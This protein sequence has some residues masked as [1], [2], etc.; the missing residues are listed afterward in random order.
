MFVLN[1]TLLS[2]AAYCAQDDLKNPLLT[3]VCGHFVSSSNHLGEHGGILTAK[4]FEILAAIQNDSEVPIALSLIN[5]IPT[6][7]KNANAFNK[8]GEYAPS[9]WIKFLL[10]NSKNI[11][12]RQEYLAQIICL[13]WAFD[14]LAEQQGESFSRGSFTIVDP[15]HKI[16]NFLLGYVR[17]VTGKKEPKTLPLVKTINNFAS[18]RKPELH[19]SSHHYGQT[20]EAQFGIDVRFTADQTVYGLLPSRHRHVLFG[21]LDVPGS[22]LPLTFVKFEPVGLGSSAEFF[23]HLLNFAN[24]GQVSGE[25]RREK[26]IPD[27]ITEAFET[28]VPN[29][30][31]KRLHQMINHEFFKDHPQDFEN[32]IGLLKETYNTNDIE[33]LKART[34]NEVV[35]DL[36]K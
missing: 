19:G 16:L 26:D 29:S 34:G 3:P 33:L 1:L 22:T 17:L 35:L 5:S 27:M 23:A 21:K 18:R 7:I 25:A 13:G 31:I 15:E 10:P 11:E 9:A 4:G 24:S 32:F 6:E 2:S 14:A 36:R 30:G 28:L 20:P 12:Q 8:I